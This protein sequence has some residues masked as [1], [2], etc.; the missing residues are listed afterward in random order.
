MSAKVKRRRIGK[1]SNYY[2]GLYVAEHGGRYY[3]AIENHSSELCNIEDDSW[4]EIEK[5]L[6]DAL[7]AHKPRKRKKQ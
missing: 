1:I 5:P 6:F 3:W 7:V 4:H 2:G